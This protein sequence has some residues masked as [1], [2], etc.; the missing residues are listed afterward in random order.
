[1][2]NSVL[3]ENHR[4]ASYKFQTNY[5]QTQT[6]IIFNHH[7]GTS[8]PLI[9]SGS[10]SIIS[11]DQHPDTWTRYQQLWL[12]VPGMVPWLSRNEACPISSG[13]GF[14]K[15]SGGAE[16]N[17]RK[18]DKARIVLSGGE[19]FQICAAFYLFDMLYLIPRARHVASSL[20]HLGA[21]T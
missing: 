6:R 14:M 20:P 5:S 8:I 15:E 13:T 1:M 19:Q 10:Q 2:G 11:Q 7:S 3:C 18:L 17:K 9:S 12:P 16:Q 4:I 21:W